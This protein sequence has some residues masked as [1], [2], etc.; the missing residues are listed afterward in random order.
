MSDTGHEHG[1]HHQPT[2]GK[3]GML[4]VGLDPIVASHLPMF[5]PPHDFQL[6]AG[7]E[8]EEA[9]TYRRDR[10]DSGEPVY[11]LDPQELS[12]KDLLPV[13]SRPPKISSFK[14]D[15][16]R[17]HFERGGTQII[18]AATVEI[19]DLAFS[20]QLSA[21]ESPGRDLTYRGVGGG[22]DLLLFHEIRGAPNFDHVVRARV[23]DPEFTTQLD[24]VPVVLRGRAD[25]L[26]ERLAPGARVGASFPQTLGPVGQHGFSCDI[27]VLD[28]VYLEVGELQ[29]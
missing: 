8:L 11:T 19:R 6:V 10:R 2:K 18:E 22:D 26:D 1:G 27:T 5:H 28:E 25:A 12:W 4:V 23:E 14:A 20:A 3:H 9:E 13:D 7:I 15:V 16:Y 21:S 29:G 17:G 24:G